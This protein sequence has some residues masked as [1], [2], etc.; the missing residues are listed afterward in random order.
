MGTDEFYRR[1]Y[2]M[3]STETPI[4]ADCGK[5]CRSRCCRGGSEDGMILFPGEE[6]ISRTQ[7][8]LRVGQGEM[9]GINTGFAVCRGKCI[10]ALRPLSCRIFPFAP[11]LRDGRLGVRK[12]PRAKRICPLLTDEAAEYIQP[13]FIDAILKAF[14]LLREIPEMDAFLQQYTA[15]MDEYEKFL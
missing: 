11:E 13:S 8:F 1:V 6:S 14:E 4:A 15:M 7:V 3:F 12:D 5:L 2:R 10:R 9:R